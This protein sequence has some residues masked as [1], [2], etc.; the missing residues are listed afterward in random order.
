MCSQLSLRDNPLVVRFV[1][2][3]TYNPPT[4]LE[5]SGRV[6]KSN[7]V[8]YNTWEIP[9]HLATYLGSA[10]QCVNPKCQGIYKCRI[11]KYVT[12]LYNKRLC[13]YFPGV[14]FDSRVEHVKFVD[15]CGKYRIPLLQYLCSPN[16]TKNPVSVECC[17]LDSDSDSGRLKKVLLG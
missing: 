7:C 2:D 5:L 16:C 8:P 4:L 15:F 13:F 1:R 17:P 11:F 14:Y 3:L 10:H 9:R 12:R 6:I